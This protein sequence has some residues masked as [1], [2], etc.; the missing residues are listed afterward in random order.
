[1]VYRRL[2]PTKHTDDANE[3]K[4]Y[5]WNFAF[6]ACFVD[7]NTYQLTRLSV[8]RQGQRSALSLPSTLLLGSGGIWIF[9]FRS[10]IFYRYQLST[11]RC[12][13]LYE[14]HSVV[15]CLYPDHIGIGAYP[16][17]IVCSYR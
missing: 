9:G 3:Q 10:L 17:G 12:P 2:M 1:M 8:Q 5:A 15:P 13:L 14:P 7:K 4:A 16:I 6:L 11:I